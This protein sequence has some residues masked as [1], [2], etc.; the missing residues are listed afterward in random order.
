MARNLLTNTKLDKSSCPTDRK[1]LVLSDG[2]SLY[3]RIYP[4]G[5]KNWIVRLFNKDKKEFP[6]GIGS[7]P[8]ISLRDARVIRD[9]YKELWKKGI[10]PSIEKKKSKYNIAKDNELTFERA[11]IETLNNKIKPKSSNK[12]IMRWEQTYNKYLLQPLGKIPLAD[13]DD[14]MLLAVLENVHRKAPSSAIKTKSQINVIYTYVKEKKWFRGT[15]PINE[16]KGNS[17]IS[18]PKVEHFTHLDEHRVGD[19]LKD[20]DKEHNLIVRTFLYVVMVT[21]LRTGSLNQARWSWLD[22][23]TN[24]LN[25]PSEHMKSRQSFRCP[26]PSQAMKRLSGL[27]D[28]TNGSSNDFIFEGNRNKSIS[29][30]TARLTLQ[31]ITG[32]KTTVHGFRTLFNIV[33]SKMGKFEIEKIEAQLTHAF[34]TT[35]I[36]KVYMGKEDYLEDRRKI[37]QAYA[38]WC[39]KQ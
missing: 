5:T 29:D 25:I 17:L 12:H 18:P 23:K 24:T 35:D 11:Y 30:A 38:D 1:S 39:D 22:N 15:N 14:S 31:K 26:I 21:A 6:K 20:L 33:V 16:L 36:R 4:N 7:Y 3:L 34:T 37:V 27:K 19:F 13:I 8:S 32:D 2:D 9:T 28:L 10:D